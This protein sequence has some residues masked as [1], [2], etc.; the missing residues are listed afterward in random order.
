MLKSFKQKLILI[1][2]IAVFIPSILFGIGS[3]FYINS[4]AR[5]NINNTIDTY[6]TQSTMFFDGVITVLSNVSQQMVY[7]GEFGRLLYSFLREDSLTQRAFLWRELHAKLGMIEFS[8]NE[9]VRCFYLIVNEYGESECIVTGLRPQIDP[10]QFQS[11]LAEN[12]AMTFFG[13]HETVQ[14][15]RSGAVISLLRRISIFGLP[16]I[17]YIPGLWGLK[18]DN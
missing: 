17:Y 2:S 12:I 1:I 3:A 16:D 6:L 10:L 5:N 7:E 14:T 18:Q 8:H 9:K 15:I 11:P 4:I 13:P